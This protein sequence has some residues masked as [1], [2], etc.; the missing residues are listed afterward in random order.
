M[1]FRRLIYR[2]NCPLAIRYI[3]LK[4]FDLHLTQLFKVAGVNW[5]EQMGV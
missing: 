1:S 5:Y 4:A 2:A 3:S